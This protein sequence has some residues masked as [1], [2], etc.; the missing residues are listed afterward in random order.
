[1]ADP[2]FYAD[3]YTPNP[4]DPPYKVLQKILGA[5]T[6]GTTPTGNFS[7]VGNPNGVVTASTGATYLDTSTMIRWNKYSGVNTNTGWG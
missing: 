5:T 6:S 1:M 3:G 7:G 2:T 4:L